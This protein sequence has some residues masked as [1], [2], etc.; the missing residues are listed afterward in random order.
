VVV[1]GVT[2]ECRILSTAAAGCG[3]WSPAPEVLDAE[4]VDEH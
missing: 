3:S 2:P 1:G 4:I